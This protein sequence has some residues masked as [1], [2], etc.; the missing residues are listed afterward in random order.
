VSPSPS[1]ER[2]KMEEDGGRGAIA[3]LKLTDY[4]PSVRRVREA[5]PLLHNHFPPLLNKERGD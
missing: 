3:P 5:K 1:K 4:Y 2:G